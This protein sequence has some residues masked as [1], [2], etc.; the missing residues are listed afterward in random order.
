MLT[1]V[2]VEEQTLCS[3]TALGF[4]PAQDCFSQFPQLVPKIDFRDWSSVC[5]TGGHIILSD[6][7]CMS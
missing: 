6:V 4:G 3:H 2:I 7:Y 1:V 5:R